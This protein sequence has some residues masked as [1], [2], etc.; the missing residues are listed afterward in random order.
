MSVRDVF[1]NSL[2]E[3]EKM[4]GEDPCWDG[5]QMVGKK[6]KNG[7]EVPNCVPK[8]EHHLD[9]EYDLGE[10]EEIT[11]EGDVHFYFNEAE[12]EEAEYQGRDVPLNK[13]MQGDV[14][15]FKVYTKNPKGNVV[16]V[17]FGDP[18]MR[19]KKSNPERRKSFRA[20]HNCDNPGPKHKARYW[21]CKKWEEEVE[22]LEEKKKKRR[23]NKSKAK[24][25]DKKKEGPVTSINKATGE[26]GQ[27]GTANAAGKMQSKKDKD[28]DPKHKRRNNKN[29]DMD[30]S[31]AMDEDIDND[32][33]NELVTE[34]ENEGSF[35]FNEETIN[36][37]AEAF[38][39]GFLSSTE[40]SN[41][42]N[43]K[44][45]YKNSALKPKGEVW[46]KN[47]KERFKRFVYNEKKKRG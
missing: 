45:V 44:A 29:I 38:M 8:E 19:I 15:K 43:C 3:T 37:L 22:K 41:G 32:L 7:K 6:K 31:I 26:R 47:L 18:N 16:K 12:I 11:L 39:A 23:S 21:S 20:R 9:E 4:K 36:L 2:Y 1:R 35:Q 27:I 28:R 46:N 5:Y 40:E 13:P 42:K 14:K 33:I 24:K 30:E 10:G 25:A 34:F 17:N